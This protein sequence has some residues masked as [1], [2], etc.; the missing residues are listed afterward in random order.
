[1]DNV[2]VVLGLMTMVST[3]EPVM[4][5]ITLVNV[6]PEVTIMNVKL[7]MIICTYTSELVLVLV[8]MVTTEINLP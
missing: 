3:E 4:L 1:V 7:V 8:Q 5:V 6:V 2:L